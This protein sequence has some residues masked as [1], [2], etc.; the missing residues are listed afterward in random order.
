ML[1]GKGLCI[2]P[3]IHGKCELKIEDAHFSSHLGWKTKQKMKPVLFTDQN[4]VFSVMA[5]GIL[6]V[7]TNISI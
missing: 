4:Q 1:G 2:K 6:P 3:T 7:I 5:S